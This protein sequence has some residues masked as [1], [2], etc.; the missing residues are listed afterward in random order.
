[1]FKTRVIGIYQAL[2]GFEIILSFGLYWLL[3]QFFHRYYPTANFIDQDSYLTCSI[4]MTLAMGYSTWKTDFNQVSLIHPSVQNSIKW[5]FQRT[6][7]NHFAILFFLFATKNETVSRFFVF[8]YFVAQLLALFATHRY[9]PEFLA[10]IFFRGMRHQKTLLVGPLKKAIRMKTW[11]SRK[12]K[13]GLRSVG[14]LCDEA[15]AGTLSD[16]KIIHSSNGLEKTIHELKVAQV[17]LLELPE[18]KSELAGLFKLCERLGVR[19]LIINDLPEILGHSVVNIEDDGFEFIGMRA[20]PLESPLNRGMKRS[21][22][23]IIAI[24]TLLFILPPVTLIVAFFQR[25]QSPG[26]IFIRQ[27]RGGFQGQRFEMFKFRTMRP[28]HGEEG[29]QATARDPRVFPAGRW[30]R[31]FSID[32]LPQF[33]NVLIGEMSVVGPRPHMV[34]HDQDFALITSNYLVRSYVKPGITG[35]SQVSGLRG[36]THQTSDLND[37]IAADI[38]YLETWSLPLDLSIIFRTIRHMIFPPKNAY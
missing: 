2:A 19:L 34:E 7:T 8:G 10:L 22:D 29:K 12:G 35:L 21:L 13:L 32:E 11:L 30:M 14:I 23:L 37:R 28:D 15:T 38:E 33:W 4:I 25:R 9:L 1:M 31:K 24:P 3:L 27:P 20:E 26:P 16:L 6:V 18:K 5:A 36:A 17:I